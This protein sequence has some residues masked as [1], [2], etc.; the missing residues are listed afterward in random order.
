MKYYDTQ[1]WFTSD[2]NSHTIKRFDQRNIIEWL[3]QAGEE[4]ERN[5]LLTGNDIG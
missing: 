3:S 1:I 2:L 4:K 5:L